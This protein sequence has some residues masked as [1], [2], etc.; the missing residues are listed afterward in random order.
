M[1]HEHICFPESAWVEQQVKPFA[2]GKLSPL[3]LR[4]HSRGPAHLLSLMNF[5]VQFF[6]LFGYSA[7]LRLSNSGCHVLPL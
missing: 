7:Q 3:P 4:G 5:F 1:L 6:K 2:G